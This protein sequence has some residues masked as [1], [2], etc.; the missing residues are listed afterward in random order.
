[1]KGIRKESTHPDP[2]A[3]RSGW[4]V[5]ERWKRWDLKFSSTCAWRR[6]MRKVVGKRCGEAE[7]RNRVVFWFECG[8]WEHYYNIIA[9]SI[10]TLRTMFCWKYYSSVLWT[11]NGLLRVMSILSAEGLF[12]VCM[13]KER[14]FV[15]IIRLLLMGRV[16]S[17]LLIII[18]G[19]RLRILMGYFSARYFCTIEVWMVLWFLF[20]V[21]WYD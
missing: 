16:S 21:F 7:G 13:F 18:G 20:D 1:M 2:I 3:K 6:G 9:V 12:F 15:C 10:V 11:F 17:D 14:W 19:C 5:G 4:R 8:C